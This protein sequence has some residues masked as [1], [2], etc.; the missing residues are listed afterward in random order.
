MEWVMSHGMSGC[1]W[2]KQSGIRNWGGKQSG[3]CSEVR[4]VVVR[5]ER[6]MGF[7]ICRGWDS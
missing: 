3:K 4:N 2:L 6:G 1:V 5:G 7:L